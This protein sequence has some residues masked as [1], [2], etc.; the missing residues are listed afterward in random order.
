[1][2]IFSL[3]KARSFKEYMNKLCERTEEIRKKKIDKGYDNMLKVSTD[4]RK[5]ALDLRLVGCDELP[6]SRYRKTDVCA[7]QVMKIY[8]EYPG[9]AQIIF[10]DYSTPKTGQVQCL[11]RNEEPSCGKRHAAGGDSFRPQLHRRRRESRLYEKVNRGIVRVLIGS[12][13]RSL[14]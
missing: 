5:A 10:C 8:E 1:M 7:E 12:T 14:A 3:R 13:F 9:C 6:E 4:G 2:T 11:R